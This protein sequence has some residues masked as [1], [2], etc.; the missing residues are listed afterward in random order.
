MVLM[1][2]AIFLIILS[3]ALSLHDLHDTH[4]KI[5]KDKLKYMLI[6]PVFFVI[7]FRLVYLLL[8]STF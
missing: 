8:Q 5:T 2:L 6:C 3:N 7:H 1:L 4:I